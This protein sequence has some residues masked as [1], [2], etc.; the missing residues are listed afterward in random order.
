MDQKLLAAL[1]SLTL[2]EFILVYGNTHVCQL[3]FERWQNYQERSEYQMYL[4]SLTEDQQ[5]DLVRYLKVKIAEQP[6]Q[7]HGTYAQLHRLCTWMYNYGHN[8][9]INMME[10][11]QLTDGADFTVLLSSSD[12]HEY[13]EAQSHVPAT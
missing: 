5:H 6:T 3:L 2:A 4:L 12:Y 1:K 7:V 9:F 11:P 8:F 10:V 13:L